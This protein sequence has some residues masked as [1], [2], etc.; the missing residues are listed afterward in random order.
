MNLGMN[1]IES[2]LALL[3][4]VIYTGLSVICQAYN[5]PGI[6]IFTVI[7]GVIFTIIAVTSEGF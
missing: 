3:I 7:I 2:L 6:M 5:M 1:K 4:G